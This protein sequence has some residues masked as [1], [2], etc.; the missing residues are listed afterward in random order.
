M[1]RELSERYP[2]EPREQIDLTKKARV[3]SVID[4]GSSSD[5]CAGCLPFFG[6]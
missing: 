4:L 1:R 6:L 5:A 3:V 2:F